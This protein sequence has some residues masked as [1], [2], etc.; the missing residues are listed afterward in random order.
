[1]HRATPLVLYANAL[2]TARTRR[3]VDSEARPRVERPSLIAAERFVRCVVRSLHESSYPPPVTA[4]LS[5]R[6]QLIPGV[7]IGKGVDERPGVASPWVMRWQC[8]AD[9]A[10]AASREIRLSIMLKASEPN[11]GPPF[12]SCSILMSAPIIMQSRRYSARPSPGDTIEMF[13][14]ALVRRGGGRCAHL[15]WYMCIFIRRKIIPREERVENILGAEIIGRLSCEFIFS[16]VSFLGLLL[17][18]LRVSKPLNR[19]A[20]VRLAKERKNGGCNKRVTS[21][22]GREP[23]RKERCTPGSEMGR[24]LWRQKT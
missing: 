10:R 18:L 17:C 15:M 24:E 9:A 16:L 12:I 23:L 13:P 4:R 11:K 7:A 8:E 5:A 19:E 6:L 22:S 2:P 1:M 20:Q 21:F 14:G 3:H